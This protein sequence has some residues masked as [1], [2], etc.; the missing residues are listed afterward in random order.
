MIF[1]LHAVPENLAPHTERSQ[2][3]L[4]AMTERGPGAGLSTIRL[5]YRA[6]KLCPMTNYACGYSTPYRMSTLQ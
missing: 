5:W 2:L 4:P 6:V 3:T 1:L